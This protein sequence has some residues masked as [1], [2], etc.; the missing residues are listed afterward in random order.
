MSMKMVDRDEGQAS[1]PRDRLRGLQADEEGADQSRSARDGNAVDLVERVLGQRLAHDGHHE[2]EVPPGRDLRDDA[3]V[4]RVQI[5]LRR[6][7]VCE[8]ATVVRDE[9]SR[10]FVTGRLERE[11]HGF[12]RLDEKTRFHVFPP[13]TVR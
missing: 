10:G 6:D 9:C 11:D 7:D 1:C 4:A 8:N 3:A 13:S 12:S 5:R 2:L